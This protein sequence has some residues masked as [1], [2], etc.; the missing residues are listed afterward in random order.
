MR[1]FGLKG[2]PCADNL[3]Q[4]IS[5]LQTREGIHLGVTPR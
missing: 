4:V 3:F 2:N 5:H 1:M